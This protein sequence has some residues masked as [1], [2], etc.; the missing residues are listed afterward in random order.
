MTSREKPH[1]SRWILLLCT[2]LLSLFVQ[3]PLR[4]AQEDSIPKPFS[5]KESPVI[6]CREPAFDF[7]TVA[8]GDNVKH[9]FV[10]ENSGTAPL[11][12]EKTKAG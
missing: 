4:A 5:A 1:I 2:G 3:E 6:S 10:L 8:A 9:R 7:G 11:I 12:I